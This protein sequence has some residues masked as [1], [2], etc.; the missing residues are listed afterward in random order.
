MSPGR[1]QFRVTREDD[2]TC[3]TELREASDEEVSKSAVYWAVRDAVRGDPKPLLRIWLSGRTVDPQERACIQD[4]IDGNYEV[5]RGTAVDP[6]AYAAALE[7][8]YR[9]PGRGRKTRDEI[10]DAVAA[11]FG[12]SFETLDNRLR[13]SKRRSRKNPTKT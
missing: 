11:E 8:K 5:P 10:V 13:R 3:K 7:V 6:I 4:Y 9:M 12:L 2:G 1:K